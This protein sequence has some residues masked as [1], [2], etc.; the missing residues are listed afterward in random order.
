MIMVI[1][2]IT[3][4]LLTAA[5][6]L[7]VDFTQGSGSG[8]PPHHSITSTSYTSPNNTLSEVSSN[9]NLAAVTMTT[10]MFNFNINQ[11]FLPLCRVM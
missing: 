8:L 10:G 2:I 1:I 9:P 6:Q 3:S 4:F 7:A 11:V 5:L